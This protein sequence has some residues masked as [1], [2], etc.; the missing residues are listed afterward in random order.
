MF[1]HGSENSNTHYSTQI[2][3]GSQR[4]REGGKTESGGTANKF[5]EKRGTEGPGGPP[6][7]PFGSLSKKFSLQY[8][9]NE[10]LPLS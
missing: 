1:C 8:M 6:G 5:L 7:G 10:H 4:C 9:N 2:L 3:M